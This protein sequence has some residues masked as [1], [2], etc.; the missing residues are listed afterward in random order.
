MN[1]KIVLAAAG[2]I[3]IGYVFSNTI[4]NIPIV[5][6]LPVLPSLIPKSA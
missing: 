4:Q 2:C 1:V 6:K 5:N 3:L